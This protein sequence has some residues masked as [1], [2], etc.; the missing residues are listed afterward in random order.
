[1]SGGPS[2]NERGLIPR[3]FSTVFGELE[4]R[5]DEID[6]QV[7]ISYFEIYNESGFDLLDRRHAEVP[8][9]QWNK[10][11]LYEDEEGEMIICNLS[12]HTCTREEE[13]LDLLMMGNYVRQVSSTPVNHVSSRSHCIFV[14]RIDMHDKQ[15]G[16]HTFSKLHLVDLAGSE[17]VH[18][19]ESDACTL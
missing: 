17:R 10:I 13:A 9:E 4:Q 16:V 15:T 5:K 1:M 6:F 18:K 11:S 2:W 3:V 8:F 14:L 7:H 19:N 12:M